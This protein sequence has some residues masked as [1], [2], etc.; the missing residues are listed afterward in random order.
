MAGKFHVCCIVSIA[1]SLRFIM[2][3]SFVLET[4]KSVMVLVQGLGTMQGHKY[5]P[6]SFLINGLVLFL[7]VLSFNFIRVTLAKFSLVFFL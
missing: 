6:M 1:L 2:A 7:I 5:L 3:L 4:M